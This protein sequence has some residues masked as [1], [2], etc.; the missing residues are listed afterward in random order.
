[1]QHLIVLQKLKNLKNKGS[2]AI[3][4]IQFEHRYVGQQLCN[5]KISKTQSH[6]LS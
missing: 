5:N 3:W 1:M 4:R 6:I 2:L